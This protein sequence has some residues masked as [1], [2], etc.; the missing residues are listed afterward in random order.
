MFVVIVPSAVSNWLRR[1]S[2]PWICSQGLVLVSWIHSCAGRKISS[3]LHSISLNIIKKVKICLKYL[4]E[5]CLNRW[6]HTFLLRG[7][8]RIL[9]KPFKTSC[10]VVCVPLC[11]FFLRFRKKRRNIR[12]SCI[13]IC[14]VAFV[15]YDACAVLC[16]G[17]V[18]WYCVLQWYVMWCS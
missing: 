1:S 4:S 6:L 11:Y 5:T 16:H 10:R 17:N 12:L 18:L 7:S 9:I 13:L 15:L 14:Y 2:A 8:S 3:R